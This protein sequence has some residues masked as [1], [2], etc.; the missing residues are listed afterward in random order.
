MHINHIDN[1]LYKK[2]K[3][4]LSSKKSYLCQ[5]KVKMSGS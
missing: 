2:K 1:T 3:N 4:K 5:R